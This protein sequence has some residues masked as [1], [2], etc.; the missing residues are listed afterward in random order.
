[1]RNRVKLALGAVAIIA[2]LLLAA[3]AAQASSKY[4]ASASKA[5]YVKTSS[6]A[7][8]GKGYGVAYA[9]TVNVKDRAHYR[10][11]I[12]KHGIYVW[13]HFYFYEYS[14]QKQRYAY[15]SAGQIR[16]TA[17]SSG[18]YKT[19]TAAKRLHLQADKAR[20]SAKVCTDVPF[21]VPGRCGPDHLLTV[22]Y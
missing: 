4:W 1:M 2:A 21:L 8:L 18:S 16:H 14:A 7:K 19:T 20:V 15:E 9:T 10:W 11:I 6:G 22:T 5:S 13:D 3:P 17:T 12:G